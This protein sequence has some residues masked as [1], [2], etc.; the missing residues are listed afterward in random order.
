MLIVWDPVF[1]GTIRKFR[2]VAISYLLTCKYFLQVKMDNV[3]TPEDFS[4]VQ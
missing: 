1:I 3:S 4:A 2:I